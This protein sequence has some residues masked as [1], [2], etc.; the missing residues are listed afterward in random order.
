M[1]A[2]IPF[3]KITLLERYV[4]QVQFTSSGTAG[5]DWVRHFDEL[6][7]RIGIGVKQH[8]LGT[9]MPTRGLLYSMTVIAGNYWEYTD[10]CLRSSRHEQSKRGL[11][12]TNTESMC[13]LKAGLTDE[14][15]ELMNLEQIIGTQGP[16]D[17]L[18]WEQPG[19]PIIRA[20]WKCTQ[21]FGSDV[22]PDARFCSAT[23]FAFIAR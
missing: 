18:D 3:V 7:M 11:Q 10:R 14:Q 22:D 16:V 9:F 8:L 23:G 20:P 17:G 4:F 6:E 5:K 13:I 2:T 1:I 21:F 12:D 19:L 15:W